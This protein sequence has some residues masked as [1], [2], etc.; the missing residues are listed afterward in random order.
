MNPKQHRFSLE[1]I[2]FELFNTYIKHSSERLALK[3]AEL[4][5]QT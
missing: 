5:T 2:Q 1:N 4:L 3:E